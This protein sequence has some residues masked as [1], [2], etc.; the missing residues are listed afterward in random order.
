MAIDPRDLPIGSDPDV[1]FFQDADGRLHP[2][3]RGMT[4]AE[5][6]H[7]QRV[8]HPV[9]ELLRSI[10]TITQGTHRDRPYTALSEIDTLARRALRE[11]G[12]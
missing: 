5:W 8:V 10:L 11:I 6:Y 9:A 7:A 12:A 1:M 4:K 3:P 2:L